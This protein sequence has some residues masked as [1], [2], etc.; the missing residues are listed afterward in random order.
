[1]V[2]QSGGA[3][4]GRSSGWQPQVLGELQ[5]ERRRRRREKEYDEEK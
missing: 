3:G 1:V 4:G 2:E 5:R